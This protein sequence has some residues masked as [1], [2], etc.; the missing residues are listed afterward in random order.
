MEKKEKT[1][2]KKLNNPNYLGAYS[3]L[4]GS[5][6][7]KITAKITKVI[8]EGVKNAKGT[9][10]CRVMYLEGYKPMI[11]NST[12]SKTIEKIY[13]TPYI[14]DWVGKMVTI[15][16]ARIKAFGEY[17]DALRIKFEL[18]KKELPILKTDTVA[19]NKVKK[20]LIE[21]YTL[22]QIKTKYTIPKKIETLLK[23]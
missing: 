17:V 21:G 10:Q 2:W 22:E 19:F 5:K 3:L 6:E 12:N 9:E 13:N 18:P 23:K 15:Y 16:V 1:H 20:A 11:L 7:P 14:E 8:T 4:D